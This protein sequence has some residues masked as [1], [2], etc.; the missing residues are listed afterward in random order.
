MTRRS[1][2]SI[3]FVLFFSAATLASVPAPGSQASFEGTWQVTWSGGAGGSTEITLTQVGNRVTGRYPY[4]NGTITGTVT[5]STLRGTWTQTNGSG[6]LEIVLSADGH[7]WSGTWSDPARDVSGTWTGQRVGYGGGDNYW[8]CKS[9]Y[10]QAELH[11]CC[12]GIN[13]GVA[14]ARE[15]FFGQVGGDPLASQIPEIARNP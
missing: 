13:L 15:H 10:N 11:V 14:G 1:C 4:E 5:G 6:R 3:W 9:N 8:Y 12:Y 7:E 2:L